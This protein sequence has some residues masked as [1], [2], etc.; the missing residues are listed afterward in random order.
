LQAME[1]MIESGNAEALEGLIGQ[2]SEARAHWR[3]GTT[4]K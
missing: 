4:S 1:V 2:A 3:M